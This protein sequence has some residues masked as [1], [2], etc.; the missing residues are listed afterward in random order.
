MQRTAKRL[1]AQISADPSPV[2]IEPPAEIPAANIAFYGLTYMVGPQ[3]RDR[4]FCP[5]DKERED[6]NLWPGE[7]R[8][9][10]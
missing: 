7:H 6:E 5:S 3:R 9:S 8:G 4:V 2:I 1:V 10:Q